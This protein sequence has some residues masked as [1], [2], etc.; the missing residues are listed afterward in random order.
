MKRMNKAFTLLELL[1]VV[2]IISLLATMLTGVYNKEVEN[3]RKATAQSDI[4]EMRMAAERFKIDVGRYPSADP[5]G[6]TNNICNNGYYHSEIVYGK[7]GTPPGEL[8]TAEKARWNGPYMNVQSAKL[9]QPATATTNYTDYYIID[10]WGNQYSY[11]ITD[12]AAYPTKV[13]SGPFTGSTYNPGG[14]QIY[15]VGPDGVTSPTASNAGG[16]GPDDINNFSM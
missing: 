14:V 8:T 9:S 11:A 6:P 15:S 2:M 16:L 1:V 3:A 13:Q 7:A 5:V 4:N 10:P 12:T